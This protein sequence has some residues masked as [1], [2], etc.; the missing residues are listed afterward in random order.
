[1]RLPS[2]ITYATAASRQLSLLHSSPMLTAPRLLLRAFRTSRPQ[3]TTRYSP[4][5]VKAFATMATDPS[6]Y[7]LNHSMYVANFSCLMPLLALT[8]LAGSG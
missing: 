5:F 3:F 2:A 8:R 7:K 4:A 1:M 6:K